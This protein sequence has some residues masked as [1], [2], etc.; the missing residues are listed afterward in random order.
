MR[1]LLFI[2]VL[3]TLLPSCGGGGS[4]DPAPT[5]TPTPT[6]NK[7]PSAPTQSAPTNN[8]L[9]I[10]NTVSFQWTASS[11][12]DGDTV[13]YEM[14]IA[15][16]NQFTQNLQ[17]NTNS[18]TS[19]S[20]SL[21]KG[22]AYYWR[23]RGKDSKGATSSYSSTFNF[24]TEGNGESNHLPF[25]PAAVKPLLNSIEQE[26][27]TTLE[28]T[29]SDVDTNDTLTFDVYFG[30]VNPPTTKISENQ[31]ATTISVDLNSSTDYYWKIVVKDDKDG[32]TIGQVWGFKTD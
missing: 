32:I 5:P 26:S 7:A 25:S 14:Q 4:D 29:A 6:V 2:I 11:D 8:L 10:D 13:S 9:C 17:T 27:S 16:D 31:S 20:V 22:I 23:V 1:K 30:T 15:T 3:S 12:P 19:T 24:Y 28:W 21:E 18:S